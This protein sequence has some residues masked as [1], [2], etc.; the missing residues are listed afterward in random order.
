M[1]K[2]NVLLNNKSWKKYIENPKAYTKDKIKLL[3]SYIYNFVIISI[4][5]LKIVIF[6]IANWNM[7]KIECKNGQDVH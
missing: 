1:I 6:M 7:Y 2:I 3:N 5:D 4:N